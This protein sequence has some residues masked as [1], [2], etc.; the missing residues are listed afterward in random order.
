MKVSYLLPLLLLAV[1]SFGQAAPTVKQAPP[2]GIPVPAADAEELRAGLKR[3]ES[4]IIQARAALKNNAALRA[5]LPDVE[6][7][8]KAV[9]DALDYDEFFKPGEIASAKQQLALGIQRA[10][11]LQRQTPSW[12]HATGTLVR[13]YRS[14]IDESV[15]PYGLIVPENW[16]PDEDRHR[17]LYLWFHGRNES[18]SEVAFIAGALKAKPQFAPPDAF[19]LHLYGRYCNA[20]KFAGEIDAFEALQDVM[21]HYAIDTNRI[22]ELGFS[23]GG[24]T[25]WHMAVHHSGVWAAASAGAGFAETAIY[26]KVF[27]GNKDL[28]PPWEQTLWHLYDATDYAVNLANVPM[29]A[30]SGEIDPQKQSADIMEKAMAQEGLKLE[31]LIGPKVAHKYEPETKK[32]LS[33]LIDA[34]VAQG[35]DPFPRHLKFA[36]YTLRYNQVKWI[37]LDR[38]EKHWE[39]AEIE[40]NL[41]RTLRI[42]T[43]NIAAFTVSLP[44]NR[45]PAKLVIDGQELEASA[46][47]SFSK[48]SGKWRPVPPD[49]RRGLAKI[50]GLTGPIDDAFM[51]SFIFVRP[52]GHPL[53]EKVGAWAQSELDRAI[54]EWRRVFRGDAQVKTDTE[55]SPEDM[56]HSHLVLWGDPGSNAV[57]AKILPDLPL[58]WTSSEISLASHRASASDH[59]PILIFPNP[60]NPNR[61][62]VLNSGF[63]FRQGSATSNS[64]Q[65]PKLPDWALID[66][67]EPPSLKWPGRVETAGFFDDHWQP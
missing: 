64:L 55:I 45:A 36:T 56:A 25:A 57:L 62:V 8:H 16:R 53:N 23:M 1:S 42:T 4:E 49:D 33:R 66:L 31:R 52:T 12:T 35:R 51:D 43:T 2:P 5:L 19:E 47:W 14:R 10:E 59:A 65:T 48:A 9:H 20:S 58:H 61:Y 67:N 40:A 24:A 63:T 26:A 28:P 7:F 11:E 32:E 17:P 37:T 15:Q 13:A 54:V 39:R 50:H 34:L 21:N 3:L 29:I 60:L 6:I 41:E 44:S 18:L 27:S 22:A 38:L 46:P 30:Y